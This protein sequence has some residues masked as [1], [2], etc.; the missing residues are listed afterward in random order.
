LPPGE[1]L[2]ALDSFGQ[3]VA[4]GDDFGG[5]R[6][7]AKQSQMTAASAADTDNADLPFRPRP[8]GGLRRSGMLADEGQRTANGGTSQKLTSRR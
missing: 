5:L 3:S 7:A 6:E 2:T 8:G 4:K 1:T